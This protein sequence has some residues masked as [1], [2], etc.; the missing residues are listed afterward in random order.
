MSSERSGSNLVRKI[1]GSHSQFF[2]PPPP[3][4]FRVF[5][6][7]T[8]FY[9]PLTNDNVLKDLISDFIDLTYIKNSHLQWEEKLD[10]DDV[11][12]NLVEK[13]PTGVILTLYDLYCEKKGFNNWVCKENNIFDHAFKI[14]RIVKDAKFIY[15]HRDP[16]DVVASVKKVPSHDTL[17]YF[18]GKEW[19][20]E[21][22]KSI[23]VYQE[24]VNS[25]NIYK[26]SYENLISNFENTVIEL[27]QFLDVDFEKGM[28]D[29]H[30]NETSINEASK[31][32]YWKNLSSPILANN[33]KKY[34]K[35]LSR[36]E[37]NQVESVCKNVML[38]LNYAF[39]GTGNVR[40]NPLEVKIMAVVNNLKKRKQQRN[41]LR[42]DGRSE[43]E[44]YFKRII[45]KGLN[46]TR[47]L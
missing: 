12:N 17:A 4:L 41:L 23:E 22:Y 46:N 13:S 44:E 28:L 7:R 14:N 18:I 33:S 6:N 42:E 5:K 30:S 47:P 38:L 27:C 15:L 39:E 3:H 31:T 20:E 16:R 29:F 45:V 2:A 11:F 32:K 25:G 34:L 43:R 1:L 8:S 9:T 26:L 19:N 36:R 37:I 40:P 10:T 21:Q 35:E 24:L